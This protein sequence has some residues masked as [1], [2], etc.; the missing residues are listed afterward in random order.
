MITKPS[1]PVVKKAAPAIKKPAPVV[2]NAAPAAKKPA[3][4]VQT[5]AEQPK[6]VVAEAKPAQKVEPKPAPVVK[7]PVEQPE[8]AV[9]E[10]KPAQK[11]AKADESVGVAARKPIVKPDVTIAEKTSPVSLSKVLPEPAKPTPGERVFHAN[12]TEPAVLVV[13]VPADASVYLSGQKMSIEGPTRRFRIPISEAGRQYQYPIRVECERNGKM[14]TAEQSEVVSA[15]RVI[16]VSVDE[17][18]LR[19]QSKIASR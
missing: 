16:T 8:A 13:N 14:L 7:K 4:V 11:S 9:A 3:P 19:R 17:S 2:R 6:A 10:T 5:P 12:P 15:G 18:E 1:A